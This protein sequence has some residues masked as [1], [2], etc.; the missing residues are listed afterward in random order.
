[1]MGK[2]TDIKTSK[3]FMALLKRLYFPS[4][5]VVEEIE[6]PKMKFLSFEGKGAPGSADFVEAIQSLY[7]VAFTTKMGMKY[8]KIAQPKHYFDFKVPP[9]EG[10]WLQPGKW[11]MAEPEKW[12]WKLKILMP[13]F[14]SQS[15]V[16]QAIAMAGA[17]HPNVPYNSVK[18]QDYEE[19]HSIQIMHIGPY[20]QEVQTVERLMAYAQEHT[21]KIV[22]HHHEIYMSDP[23]RTKED[24]LKTVLRYAVN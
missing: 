16:D 2:Y 9:L 21:E 23:R 11:D 7:G 15:L 20:A 4:D 13:S 19:G 22:G 10:F 14:V 6:V 17:K 8:G 24:R 1:M 12:Q 5:K 18:L 3:E